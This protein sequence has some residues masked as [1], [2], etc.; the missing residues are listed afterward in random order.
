MASV[1]DAGLPTGRLKLERRG[2]IALLGLDR[3]DKRNALDDPAILALEAFFSAPPDD[4]R[5]VVL[6]GEGKHFS[7]GLDLS[8]LSERSAAAGIAHSRRWHRAFDAIQFGAVPVVALLHGAVVGGGLELAAATHVRIAERSTFYALPEG[9]RGIFVGG[10][11]SVR[12]TRLIGVSRVMDMMLTG[13]TYTA[14]EGLAIGLSQY[15]VD[16]RDAGLAKAIALAERIA[17]NAPLTN[18]AI[19]QALPRIAESGQAEGLLT[20]S[21]MTALAQGDPEAK[22]R[23]EA[24]LAKRAPKVGDA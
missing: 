20:E 9:E 19:L 12:I 17:G 4:V 11:G 21:L 15:V 5:A 6:Y 14:E 7:A 2:S 1:P 18:F 8:E 23:I 3:A 22:R 13:R 16:G 10:G 24:F